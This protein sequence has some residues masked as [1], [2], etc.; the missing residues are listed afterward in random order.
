MFLS[1][2]FR[3]QR[4][5]SQF[6]FAVS[7]LPLELAQARLSFLL[8]ARFAPAL[9]LSRLTPSSAAFFLRKSVRKLLRSNLLTGCVPRFQSEC[10]DYSRHPALL[11]HRAVLRQS[12][13]DCAHAERF[14]RVTCQERGEHR[15]LLQCSSK[16]H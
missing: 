10:D 9:Q 14:W 1:L 12:A 7:E 3:F 13:A 15:F 8:E 4:L 11:A 16:P 5:S 6:L 2:F